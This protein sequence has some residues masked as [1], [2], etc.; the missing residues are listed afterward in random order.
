MRTVS[1]G[2]RKSKNNPEGK[3]KECGVKIFNKQRHAQYCR[4]CGEINQWLNN[5]KSSI[6][7]NFKNNFPK[8]K[9]IIRTRIIKKD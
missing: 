4:D 9:L 7:N 8:H 1:K 3:C 2:R 6:I 5:R